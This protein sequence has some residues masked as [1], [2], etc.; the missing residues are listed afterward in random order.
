MMTKMLLLLFRLLEL[1]FLALGFLTSFFSSLGGAPKIDLPL[2]K[3]SL[4]NSVSTLLF[5]I[6]IL[7]AGGTK[8]VVL[9]KA[10]LGEE[11]SYPKPYDQKQIFECLTSHQAL[12]LKP[13]PVEL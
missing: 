12:H 13:S 11:K 3:F 2:S 8:T 1:A 4:A 7:L 5:S 10:L 9:V 6:L